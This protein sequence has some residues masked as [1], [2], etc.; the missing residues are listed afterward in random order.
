MLELAQPLWLLPLPLVV[1]LVWRRTDAQPAA[2]LV[3]NHPGLG[4]GITGKETAPARWPRLFEVMALALL[5]LALAQP[6]EVGDW[7]VPPPEG[8]DIVLVVDTSQTMSIDD[9]QLAGKKA[10][11]LAVL[12]AVLGRFIQGRAGDRFGVLAFGS[13]AATLTPP[14]FDHAHVIAQ[15]ERLQIGMAGDN[16]A[17]GDALGL[18]VKQVRQTRLRPV[19]IL[20]SDGAESNSGDLTPGEAVAVARQLGVAVHTLQ[21]G[22]DL[23]A[24]GRPAN[25]V[26]AD[27]QPG[28]A[29][30]ARLSGG[31]HWVV[32]STEDAEQVINAIGKLEPSLARPARHRQTREWYWLPLALGV[33]LLSLAQ[34]TRLRAT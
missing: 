11:R 26:E 1:W 7:I 16:T 32:K 24:A 33:A 27:P 3:L 21:I 30:I 25:A 31:Q 17:L 12:K 14:T 34:F 15:I 9:F 4:L 22:G 19:V 10:E 29:D 13:T 2:S 18:A 28:L 23:F 8:R 20:L 6:R 5:L